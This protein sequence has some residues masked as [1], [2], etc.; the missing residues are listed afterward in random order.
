M[1]GLGRLL[2]LAALLFSLAAA[3]AQEAVSYYGF[4]FPLKIGVLTRGDI[5][6]FEK[7][8]PGG[9]VGIRY[10]A[11]GVRADIFVYDLGKRSISWDVFSAD[12]KQELAGSIKAIYDAKERGLYRDVKEGREFETPAVKNPFFRCKVLV[13]DRGEGRVED[14]VLCLGAQ[15]NKF[16]KTRLAF[17]PQGSDIVERADKLMREIARATNF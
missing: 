15:N 4:S 7:S 12:Q 3:S 6:D 2:A 9:G 1:R 16:F 11:P 5:T 10:T 8:H 14:S 17:A 13:I